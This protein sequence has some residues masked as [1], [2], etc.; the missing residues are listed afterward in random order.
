MRYKKMLFCDNFLLRWFPFCKAAL[1]VWV[2]VITLFQQRYEIKS[3]PQSFSPKLV[4]SIKHISDKCHIDWKYTRNFPIFVLQCWLVKNSWVTIMLGTMAREKTNW[5]HKN[6]ISEQK[7][8]IVRWPKSCNIFVK[9]F[10]SVPDTSC[11]KTV[12]WQMVVVQL[13]FL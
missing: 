13:I 10:T 3:P 5:K 9:A 11:R 12:N 2:P 4:L 8:L 1:F 7:S 6:W